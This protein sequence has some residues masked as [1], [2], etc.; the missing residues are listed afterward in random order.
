MWSI[1]LMALGG[2]L[3]GGAISLRRQKAHK[4]WI[5]V[6]WVLAGLSLLAAYMLTLR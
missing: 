1:L 2:L 6:L 3:A 4:S 5:V